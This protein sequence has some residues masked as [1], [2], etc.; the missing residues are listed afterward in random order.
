MARGSLVAH[1]MRFPTVPSCLCASDAHSPLSRP[2][3]T[4]ALGASEC[5]PHLCCSEIAETVHQPPMAVADD[6]ARGRPSKVLD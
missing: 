3:S 2:A 4:R 6:V 5:F 1:R